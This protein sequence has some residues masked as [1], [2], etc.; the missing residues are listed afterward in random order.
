MALPAAVYPGASF[1]GN[2]QT[3]TLPVGG[4]D[5]ANAIDYNKATTEVKALQDDLRAAFTSYVS[6]GEVPTDIDKLVIALRPVECQIVWGQGAPNPYSL[7]AT[8]VQLT[9]SASHTSPGGSFATAA[10]DA[11]TFGSLGEGTYRFCVTLRYSSATADKRLQVN[12][13][14]DTVQDAALV[15]VDEHGAGTKHTLY[16]EGTIAIIDTNVIDVRVESDAA[17]SDFTIGGTLW[18]QRI[19]S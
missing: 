6:G 4:T 2:E 18:M 19:R 7:G 11:I 12:L 8:P 3:Q 1:D 13:Y 15:E 10:A 9:G 17:A 5:V 14:K 16:F